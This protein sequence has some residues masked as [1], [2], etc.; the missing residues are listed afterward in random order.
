MRYNV[1]R[2]LK[3]IREILGLTQ[4]GLAAELGVE[5]ATVS[6]NESG[7]T[8]PSRDFLE[9]MYGLAFRRNIRLNRMKEMLR[10]ESLPA[11]HRLLFCGAKALPDGPV[12]VREGKPDADFGP[13]FYAAPG[14]EQAVFSV[15]VPDR[16]S[17]YL[18]DFD[19]AGLNCLAFTVSL[20]WM[21]TAAYFRGAL[22]RYKDHPAV[23]ACA[24][25]ARSADCIIA[26]AADHRMFQMIESFFSGEITDAQCLHAIAD[27]KPSEQAVLI[28]E[29]A[30]RRVKV[31]DRCYVSGEERAYYRSARSAETE[32]GQDPAALARLRFR[33]KGRYIQDIM[34]R[35]GP[36]RE[37]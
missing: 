23:I 28:S 33:G 34:A 32:P 29:K 36:V 31:T 18:L 20:E 13:G 1:P 19:P 6:R 17:V 2:D 21:M 4:A 25:R 12:S 16:P 37:G 10:K 7:R 15:S 27:A 9:K 11:G 3:V 35:G 24:Q 14:F 5:Q 30:A 26:P 8:V 22:F